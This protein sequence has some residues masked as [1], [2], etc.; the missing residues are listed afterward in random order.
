MFFRARFAIRGGWF[1]SP[2]RPRYPLL[3]RQD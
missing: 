2:G 3:V 1:Q